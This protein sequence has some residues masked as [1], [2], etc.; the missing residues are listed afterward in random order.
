MAAARRRSRVATARRERARRLRAPYKLKL[1][2]DPAGAIA[3]SLQQLLS[4][5]RADGGFAAYQGANESDP[6]VTRRRARL[7]GSSPA[8]AASPSTRRRSRARPSFMAQS[9]AN[10]ARYK[11]CADV[12]GLQ[13]AGALRN[14]VGASGQRRPPD[15]FP[16]RHRRACRRLRLRD[17]DSL[18]ALSVTDRRAGRRKAPRMADHLQQTLYVT[19]RYAVANVTTRWGWLGSLV[20]AQV[21]DA[22]VADRAACAGRTA[23]R[24]RPRARR[25]AM[26]VRVAD[27]GRHGLGHVGAE[28]LRR[29]R[30]ARAGDGDGQGRQRRDRHGAVRFDRFVADRS[31]CR[32]RRCTATR[33]RSPRAQARSTTRCSTPTT[34]RPTPPGELAAFRVDSHGK[35]SGPDSSSPVATWISLRR[36]PSRCRPVAF[37]T[38][39]FA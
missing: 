23:R 27:D 3:G 13:G 28:R 1:D 19:G 30:T 37:T 25:A 38:S 34:S 35:R 36:P 33:S 31:P 7:A 26:Q 16:Q 5:Q 14:A 18:G 6:F 39:A 21:A 24:R 17:A 10:P 15:R 20:R 11:W 9:L 8:R 2:F 22:A 12:P 4:L 29:D 32:P